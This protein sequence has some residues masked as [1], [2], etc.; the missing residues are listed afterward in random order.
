VRILSIINYPYYRPGGGLVTMRA[1][2]HQLARRGHRVVAVHTFATYA[3]P[4]GRDVLHRQAAIEFLE[5]NGVSAAGHAGGAL[6]FADGPVDVHYLDDA[7][8]VGPY[9]DQL[10]PE[11]A[12]DWVQLAAHE[13]DAIGDAVL[14]RIDPARILFT[15]HASEGLPFG[16]RAMHGGP[17]TLEHM[18]AC[19]GIWVPSEYVRRYLEAHAGLAS[20]VL[21]ID[22]Y[23]P[24]PFRQLGAWD[25]GAVTLINSSLPKGLPVLAELARAFPEVPFATVP[26][27]EMG[28]APSDPAV[29]GLT[30]LPP[31]VALVPPVAHAEIDRI[32]EQVRVLL[33]PSLLHEAFGLVVVEAMLRGIPVLASDVGG[34]PE[35]K[36]GVPYVLPLASIDWDAGSGSWRQPVQEL[37]PWRDALGALLGDR[38]LYDHIAARSREAA[39]AFIASLREDGFERFVERLADPA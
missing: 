2:Y 11:L 35:A 23:G 34:L 4:L 6:R 33:A 21:P 27:W 32:Y 19:R 15:C 18:R 36:L 14:A 20:T 25:R 13:S 5:K 9:L 12:P 7:A 10:L 38:A 39:H 29:A 3:P 37:G 30:G 22:V 1:L 24:R 28:V 8:A 31:N 16:P 26:T 17:R